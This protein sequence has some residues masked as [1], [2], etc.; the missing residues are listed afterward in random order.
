MK[1]PKTPTKN[2]DRHRHAAAAE[3]LREANKLAAS[4]LGRPTLIGYRRPPSGSTLD[5]QA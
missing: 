4:I 1:Q 5:I 3:K 2:I